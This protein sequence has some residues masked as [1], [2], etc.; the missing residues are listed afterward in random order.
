MKKTVLINGGSRGIGAATVRLF[1]KNGYN[2][3]FTYLSSEEELICDNGM[4]VTFAFGATTLA[5]SLK[6]TSSTK[7]LQELQEGHLPI[8]LAVS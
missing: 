6:R 4:E 7:L 1:A 5:F 8:H 2:V 3:A